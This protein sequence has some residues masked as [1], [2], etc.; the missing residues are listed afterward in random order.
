[1]TDM[2]IDTIVEDT[3][4]TVVTSGGEEVFRAPKPGHTK[5][6]RAKCERWIEGQ[7]KDLNYYR[8]SAR[9]ADTTSAWINSQRK[10]PWTYPARDNITRV[11]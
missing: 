3:R 1:M 10:H 5:S 11:R 6:A 2:Q 8:E 9:I 4:W 7:S